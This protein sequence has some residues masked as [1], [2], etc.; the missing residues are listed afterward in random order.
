MTRTEIDRYAK[1]VMPFYV[2]GLT[3]L[4]GYIF[5]KTPV[6]G[7]QTTIH[8]AVTENLEKYSGLYFRYV[9]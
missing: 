1:Q 9:Y 4:F 2:V 3:R 5:L 8:C 6:Q 7:A